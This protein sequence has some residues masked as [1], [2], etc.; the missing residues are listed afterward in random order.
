MTNEVK[1]E[2][3]ANNKYCKFCKDLRF[4][5]NNK[6]SK[7]DDTYTD[8]LGGLTEGW[9]EKWHDLRKN[10]N[11]LPKDEEDFKEYL[12]AYKNF[13]NPNEIVIGCFTW[14][15]IRFLENY[16][17]SEIP[18]FKKEGVLIAWCEL[19]KFEE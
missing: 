8:Y 5:N 7:W 10:P 4:C 18:Y 11:D 9:K 14:N 13:N 3:Y 16:N 19:P 1:A 17:Y 15:G 12:V 6:C 2:E